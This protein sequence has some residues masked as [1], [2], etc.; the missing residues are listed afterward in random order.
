MFPDVDLT[1]ANISAF[2]D[3]TGN[4]AT[5]SLTAYAI[6]AASAEPVTAIVDR[7][8]RD[9]VAAVTLPARRAGCRAASEEMWSAAWAGSDSMALIPTSFDTT[10]VAVTH[11]FE[12]FD[13]GLT[14][15]AICTT[16]FAGQEVVSAESPLDSQAGEV[17]H[18]H[19]SGRQARAGGRRLHRRRSP[20]PASVGD[21]AAGRCADRGDCAGARGRGRR[22][23]ELEGDRVRR[24]RGCAERLATRHGDQCGRVGRVR[25]DQRELPGGQA[26]GRYRWRGCRGPGRGAARRDQR[27]RRP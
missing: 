14:A 21:G 2:E 10:V 25:A 20:P 3:G 13:W 26:S 4:D 18:G 16:P 15:Q 11:P 5:W 12:T 8:T 23:S 6:C 19:L 9:G 7:G 22:R 27:R 1:S 17:G 24:L